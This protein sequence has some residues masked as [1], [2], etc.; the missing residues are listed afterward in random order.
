MAAYQV[1]VLATSLFAG[2][3]SEHAVA[4]FNYATRLMELPQ[5]IVGI[6]LATVL[7]T[8][9]SGLAADKK[10]PKFHRSPMTS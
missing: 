7:L 3:T 8:E 5:G 10:Y 2:A 4:S 6:S 9:L 1:N